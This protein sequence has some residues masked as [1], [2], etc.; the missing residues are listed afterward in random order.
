MVLFPAFCIQ[1][2]PS[3]MADTVAGIK[4]LVRP[5]LILT[6]L[7][8]INNQAVFEMLIAPFIEGG[9]PIEFR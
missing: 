1:A 6:D 9:D 3:D 2:F 4:L 7:Y 8:M 5:R